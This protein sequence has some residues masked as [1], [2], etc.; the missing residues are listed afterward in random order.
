[1]S[2]HR[3]Y[4]GADL[5][6]AAAHFVGDYLALESPEASVHRQIAFG[7]DVSDEDLAALGDAEDRAAAQDL[8]RALTPAEEQQQFVAIIDAIDREVLERDRSEQEQ[9][10][11]DRAR[12]VQRWQRRALALA[13]AAAIVVLVFDFPRDPDQDRALIALGTTYQVDPLP[14]T[15]MKRGSGADDEMPQYL[16]SSTLKL[17]LRPIAA[18]EGSVEVVGFVRASNGNTRELTFR[19]QPDGKGLVEITANVH[20]VGLEE[21][22]WELMFVVGR[23]TTLPRSWEDAEQAE[24]AGDS[25]AFDVLPVVK[26]QVT[27]SIW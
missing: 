7:S 26:F 3:S 4:H 6:D 16:P 1:M 12:R 10:A 19:Q 18:V 15:A 5:P 17:T 14:G 13:A 2:D 20:E 25:I 9:R 11:R 22:E 21:G 23:P 24:A 27:P 8:F